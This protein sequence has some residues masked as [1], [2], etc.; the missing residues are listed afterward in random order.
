MAAIHALAYAVTH[1]YLYVHLCSTHDQLADSLTKV[2]V[3]QQWL[4]MHNIMLNL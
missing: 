1:G 2:T 3:T 4:D